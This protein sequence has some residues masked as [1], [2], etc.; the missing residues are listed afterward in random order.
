MMPPPPL[1]SCKEPLSHHAP[2]K[3]S[4]GEK[5]FYR[6][7]YLMKPGRNWS[8]SSWSKTRRWVE[9]E[10]IKRTTV[11]RPQ[12]APLPQ[13]YLPNS[14]ERLQRS[15]PWLQGGQKNNTDGTWESDMWLDWKILRNSLPFLPSQCAV[16]ANCF[17]LFC[18]SFLIITFSS[19]FIEI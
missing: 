2:L 17:C 7:V 13:F 19:S 4:E 16:F 6:N 5:G 11:F 15:H 14:G 12:W 10:R 1:P 8:C 3:R 18:F 9:E